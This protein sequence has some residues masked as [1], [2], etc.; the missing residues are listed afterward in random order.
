MQPWVLVGMMGAGKTTVGRELA[1]R[2]RLRFIDCDQ[3]LIA[4]TGVPIQTIFEVEGEAGFRRRESAL[5]EEL[6]LQKDVVLATGGGVVLSEANR[7]RLKE[8]ARVIFINTPA[9]IIFERTRGDR[10]RP[11]L[12]VDNPLERIQALCLERLPLYREVADITIEGGRPGPLSTVKQI[13]KAMESYENP[14]CR[15]G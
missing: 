11:L 7:K 12:Q 9:H 5:L 6:I 1:R 15:T 3:E 13:E 2:H 10:N 14:E 8:H 4:R